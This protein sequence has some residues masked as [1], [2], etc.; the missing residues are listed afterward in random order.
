MISTCQ[1]CKLVFLDYHGLSYH[2]KSCHPIGTPTN[3]TSKLKTLPALDMKKT[4][5]EVDISKE[6]LNT[7]KVF[8]PV[9]SKLSTAWPSK[10][11]CP[12]CSKSFLAKNKNV[13]HPTFYHHCIK[14]CEKYQQL[15]EDT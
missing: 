14:D 13:Y 7:L 11:K 6:D 3:N 2:R 8:T 9:N 10:V 12:G 4:Q 1:E 15:G 5:N